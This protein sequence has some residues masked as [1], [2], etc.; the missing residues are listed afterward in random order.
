V[1]P[2]F[3]GLAAAAYDWSVEAET[4]VLYGAV[5]KNNSIETAAQHVTVYYEEDRIIF[6][7]FGMFCDMLRSFEEEFLIYK[8]TV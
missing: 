1:T 3:L 6:C 8:A 5:C 4:V 7:W 2:K